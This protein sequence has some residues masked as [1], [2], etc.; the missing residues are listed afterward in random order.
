MSRITAKFLRQQYQTISKQYKIYIK[1][2]PSYI[3]KKSTEENSYGFILRYKNNKIEMFIDKSHPNYRKIVTL[4]HETGHVRCIR[5]NCF[6]IK[7]IMKMY[8]I[9][10][11]IYQ[12]KHAIEFSLRQLIDNEM[13]KSLRDEIIAIKVLSKGNIDDGIYATASKMVMRTKLWREAIALLK[14]ASRL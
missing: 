12:E 7:Y 11:R 10:N 9:R 13:I 6:C 1:E 2:F 4:Y 5:N 8:N 14:K 3:I